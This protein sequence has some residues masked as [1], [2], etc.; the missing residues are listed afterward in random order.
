MSIYLWVKLLHVLSA[1]ILFGTGIGT[2]FFMLRAYLSDSEEAMAVTTRNVV[3]ADSVFTTPAVIVQLATGMWLVSQLGVSWTSV[4][5]VVV[6]GL[7][8]LVGACWL[9]VVWIQIRVRDMLAAGDGRRAYQH[10]MRTWIA[11]G[12]P[13]FAG[14]LALFFLMVFKPGIGT[15]L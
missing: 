12:I 5:F 15:P 9:P 6:I 14:V 7:F 10:L 2:A 8:V 1:T 13:A 4:W 3:L 11:L